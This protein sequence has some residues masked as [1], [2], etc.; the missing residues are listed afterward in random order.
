MKISGPGAVGPTTTPR[1]ARK[2]G[3]SDENF[4]K[5]LSNDDAA[6]AAVSSSG[7]LAA[8]DALLALQE[9]PDATDG[10]SRAVKRAEGL[11]AGLDEIRQGLLVGVIPKDKLDRLV[12]AVRDKR[13]ALD[14]PRLS[15]VLDEIELRASV[16]LAK[17]EQLS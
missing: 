7:P 8:V 13:E 16:E 1:K 4:A 11:L 9:V 14:D 3:G 17:L 2:A 6:T 12:H 5:H 10:R 15:A